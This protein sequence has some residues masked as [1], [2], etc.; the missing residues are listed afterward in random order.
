MASI[1][2]L[3]GAA[4]LAVLFASSP[5]HAQEPAK[6]KYA[7]K[8]SDEKE[9]VVNIDDSGA[10]DP[11]KRINFMSQGNFFVNINTIR[12][13]TLHLSHFPMFQIN[14][15]QLQP[16]QGGRFEIQNQ[17]LKAKG[18]GKKAPQGFLSVWH[19][20]NVRITQTTELYP[21]KAKGPGEKRLMNNV[22][23]TY[24]LE[25]TGKQ[26]LTAGMRVCMD[27]FV[28]DNDGCLFAAPTMPGQV[29]D[30]VVLK[31][32]TLPPYFQM[33]QRPDLKNS[34]YR[35]HFTINLG[36][37]YEKA[38]KVVLSSLRAGFQQWDMP[39]IKA[40]GDSAISVYWE[41]KE[42]K[43]GAKRELA[44]AYGE[45]I[46]VPAENEGRFQMSLG[47]SFEPGKIFTI[48]ALVADPALGQTL[49]LDLPAG[50][51][52]VE[53][54]EVQ[55]VAPLSLDNEY[56]TVLWK[57]RVLEPGTH[58]IRVRSSTGITQGKVVAVTPEK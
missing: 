30:G 54:K 48:S 42:L 17:P 33:L 27:T 50:M 24:T 53:G 29:L 34:G 31:D 20:N 45:G 40:M 18:P 44:Y 6:P 49:S 58:T 39:A 3:F 2:S 51:V 19:V 47:G 13:E 23:V 38:N 46:A 15:Q 1:R 8:I 57:C 43:P 55:P 26:A 9:V 11:A 28:I 52:R 21:S 32:K 16:G 36:G 10:I 12:N 41:T 7:V 56:S 5:P 35:S 14:G 37:K 22:F 25:N 4:A